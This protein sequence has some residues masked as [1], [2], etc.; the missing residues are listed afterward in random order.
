M[1][2]LLILFMSLL[3]FTGCGTDMGNTADPKKLKIF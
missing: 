2:R 3:V 1:K